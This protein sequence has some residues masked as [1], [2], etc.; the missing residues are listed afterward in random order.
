VLQKPYGLEAF[1]AAL[2]GLL[3]SQS[4]AAS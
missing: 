3:G 4:T 2:R 1:H